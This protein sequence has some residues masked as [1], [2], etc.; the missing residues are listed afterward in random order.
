M[1]EFVTISATR[2][3]ELQELEKSLPILI[4]EAIKEYKKI[5][6]RKTT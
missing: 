5:K 3:K 6:L 4:D 2:L 1:E